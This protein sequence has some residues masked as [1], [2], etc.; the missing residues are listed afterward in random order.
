MQGHPDTPGQLAQEHGPTFWEAAREIILQTRLVLKPGAVCAYVVKNFVRNKK[1][2]PFCDDWARLLEMC[3]FRVFLRW[4]MW[5]ISRAKVEDMFT[6][7]AKALREFKGFFRRN[8][9]RKGSPR[10]DFEEC[11]WAQT[12]P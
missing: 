1:R 4:R 12:V 5:Q 6:G 9:E 7:D 3:G 8:A 2:V 10:I 11:I